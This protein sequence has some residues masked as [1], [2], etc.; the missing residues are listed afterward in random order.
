MLARFILPVQMFTVYK[1]GFDNS[2]LEY[3]EVMIPVVGVCSIIGK[4]LGGLFD[5]EEFKKVRCFHVCVGENVILTHAR[6]VVV[7]HYCWFRRDLRLQRVKLGI[8]KTK[9]KNHHNFINEKVYGFTLVYIS[10]IPRSL[11]LG[12]SQSVLLAFHLLPLS[13]RHILKFF[14]HIFVSS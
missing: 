13:S 5:P 14:E 7:R 3:F 10:Q 11:L 1:S 2:L 4:G 9:T 8:T 6:S 12:S